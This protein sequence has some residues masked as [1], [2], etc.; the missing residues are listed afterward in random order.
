MLAYH[1]TNWEE[2]PG[3]REAHFVVTA[4][5]RET[6]RRRARERVLRICR[7]LGEKETVRACRAI[8]RI[9]RL[10]GFERTYE[11]V[12]EARTIFEGPGMLVR[13]GSRRRTLGGIFFQL[14]N[15]SMP[16]REPAS[17]AGAV[18]GDEG[19]KVG[20]LL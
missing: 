1:I 9:T 6:S 20:V 13:N 5:M 7:A 16:A 19:Q 17:A 12:G 3:T 15:A 8:G 11:L 14:A 2:A 18:G 10:L 4:E